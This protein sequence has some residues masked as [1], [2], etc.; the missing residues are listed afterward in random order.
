MIWI[1]GTFGVGKTTAGMAL[2]D[3][4]PALRQFDPEVVGYMLA[5][6]LKD[7]T[8]TD[9]QDLPAWRALVPATAVAI[10]R[11]TGQLLVAVQTVM[12]QEYWEEMKG[13]FSGLGEQIFHVVLDADEASLRAWLSKKGVTGYPAML[14]VMERF[15]YPDYLQASA[16]DLIETQYADRPAMRAIYDAVLAADEDA[17]NEA[18]DR[19]FDWLGELVASE[20]AG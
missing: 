6:S 4:L 12:R 3:G 16:D 19:H 5:H 17:A 2:V 11:Q 13:T 8:F 7:Q 18:M 14:L 20:R 10:R 9:F 1:N 15:G